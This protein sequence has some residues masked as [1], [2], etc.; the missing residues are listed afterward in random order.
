MNVIN[1]SQYLA[2]VLT[3]LICFFHSVLFA[4]TYPVL[5][6]KCCKLAHLRLF[7]THEFDQEDFV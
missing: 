6:T 5:K 1:T 3:S 7:C 4:S 2:L